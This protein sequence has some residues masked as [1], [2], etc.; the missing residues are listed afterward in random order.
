MKT[1]IH[2]H[3]THHTL[4]DFAEIYRFATESLKADGLHLFPELYLTGYP[5][6][7]LV[8]QRGFVEAYLEHQEKLHLW[9]K[10]QSG[11]WRALMGGLFYEMEGKVPKK[12]QNVIYEVIPGLGLKKLYAKRLLPNYDIFDEQKYFSPGK[13][14]CFYE[15]NGETFGLQICEDMWHSSFHEVDPCELMLAEV[16]EKNLKLSAVINLSASPYEAAKKSKR[17]KRAR[18]ISLLFGC[19]FI[20]VNRVGGEDEILFDGTS[21][22]MDGCEL[23]KELATFK[24]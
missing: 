5:L 23:I 18:N 2:L 16:R 17:L 21:F 11:N 4:A 9:A 22:V 3:Q 13:G 24:M 8:L 12:I 6:Q 10:T 14:N 19:P 1:Q 7:D 20:Y 15:L